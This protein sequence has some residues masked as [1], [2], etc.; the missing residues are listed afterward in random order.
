MSTN[1]NYTVPQNYPSENA[2]NLSIS[3]ECGITYQDEI[4]YVN[5]CSFLRDFQKY[6]LH[7]NYRMD[8]Q[9]DFRNVV[10]ISVVSATVPNSIGITGEPFITLDLGD[11]NHITFESAT[12][13]HSGF[14]NI[15]FDP[16][17]GAFI[18]CRPVDSSRIFKTPLA[19]LS[20]ISVT[21]RDV[22]GNIY[23]FGSNTGSFLKN[24]QNSF[25]LKIRCREVCRKQLNIRN[26]F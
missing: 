16:P 4:H 14:A 5:I 20:S 25:L 22:L 8:L 26:V 1:Q 7:Y 10:E 21:F 19:R 12:V 9:E 17:V 2:S 18:Q 3:Q 24:D 15:L 11:L 13:P 23:N 6:P